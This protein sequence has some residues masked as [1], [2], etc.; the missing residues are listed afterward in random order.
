MKIGFGWDSHEVKSGIPLKIG[1]V[2]LPHGWEKKCVPGETMPA[3]VHGE[4]HP[5]P[6]EL[7]VKLPPPPEPALTVT[8][9]V[10]GKI[11]RLV[12]ATHEILDVFDVEVDGDSHSFLNCG[13]DQV[14]HFANRVVA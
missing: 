12:K 10:E 1:G 9:A 8:V 6:A 5:L 14:T 7:V 13:F 11:V 3:V 4:C 2:T